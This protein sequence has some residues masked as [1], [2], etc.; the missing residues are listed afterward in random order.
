MAKPPKSTPHSDMDGVHQDEKS[1]VDT[2]TEAG[3]SGASLARARKETK[4][5]PASG[6]TTLNGKDDR[7]G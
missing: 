7:T 6:G 5:R 2:A 4:A 3:Q 1:N